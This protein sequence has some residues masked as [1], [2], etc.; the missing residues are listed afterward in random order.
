MQIAIL[1]YD[2]V[3][4]LD[5]IGPFDTLGG[6]PTPRRCSSRSGPAPCATTPGNSH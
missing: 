4:A 2:R 5:A 3:T 6:S 1:L